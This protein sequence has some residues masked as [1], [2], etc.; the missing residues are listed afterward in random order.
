MSTRK[1]R[2][3]RNEPLEYTFRHEKSTCG[4]FVQHLALRVSPH[5]GLVLD[6]HTH[7]W[8]EVCVERRTF[9]DALIFLRSEYR[10]RLTCQNLTQLWRV[11]LPLLACRQDLSLS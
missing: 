11:V 9:E 1:R 3:S 7:I 10:G 4:T 8:S 2:V 5:K 6:T